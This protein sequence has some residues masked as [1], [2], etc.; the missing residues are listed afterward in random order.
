MHEQPLYKLL[1]QMDYDQLDE[2]AQEIREYIKKVVFSNNGHLASNFGVVELT[3]SLYRVFD[4]SQDVVIWDTSHQ[5]YVHK[6][7]TG[8]WNSFSTLRSLNGISG[9][10]SIKESNYD[11]F[12]AGHA[13]TSISAALGYSLADSYKNNNRSIIAVIGDGSINCGMALESLNQLKYQ[14]ANIKIILNNND[15][16]ISNNVGALAGIFSRL[17]TKREYYQ[18]KQFVKDTLS[19]SPFG[20]DLEA[21]LKKIKDSIKYSVYRSPVGYFEDMGIKYFGPVDGHN[22]S[23]LDVAFS[24]LKEY[25]DSP[26]IL[27]VITKKGKGL[28]EA[29][30][31]P[32]KFHGV[33]K[34]SENK[35][36]SYSTIVGK[37]LAYLKGY[38]FVAF[39][40]AMSDGTGLE[41]LKKVAPGK[42]IDMGITEPSIVTTAAAFSLNGILPV[43]AI[44]STF[45][46]RAFDSIIHDVAL[47][48]A[49][50]LFL[51]DRAGLV[52]EDGPTHHGAFDIS[53]LRL[54]P[55]IRIL[56]PIDGQDLAD[57]LYTAIVKGIKEPTFIRYPKEYENNTIQNIIDSVKIVDEEWI[58]IKKST[59]KDYILGVGT[60]CKTLKECVKDYDINVI[61]VRSV[62]PLDTA[63]MQELSEKAENILVFEEGSLKGG[64]NEEIFKVCRKTVLP[65]GIKDSFIPAGS[66]QELLN[67]CGLD[68]QKIKEVIEAFIRSKE[69]DI[70]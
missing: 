66:R 22:I 56:T 48:N 57:M 1:K 43:V 6:L 20:Q 25:N 21:V 15:M 45:M 58:Y 36:P 12:G 16:S 61:A 46:Q 50:V 54:I 67:M 51:L 62:K 8:R 30:K 32:T 41:E 64:F 3:L 33:S 40:A 27:H 4:P 65:F 39:T 38:D 44:Y 7:L 24:L 9:F 55:D 26:A 68:H 29:E 34:P 63:V 14:N 31:N 60:I 69:M 52:G 11:R 53:F 70:V 35:N 42:V 59:S 47:Q 10:T 13:G 23:E 28:E 17:R 37:V 5:S 19:E 49:P 18:F 2:L